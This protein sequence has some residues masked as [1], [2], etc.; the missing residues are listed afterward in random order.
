MY[1]NQRITKSQGEKRKMTNIISARDL[2]YIV[3]I[4]IFLAT[5]A[6]AQGIL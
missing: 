3:N 6:I 2:M 5:A 4:G 1:D